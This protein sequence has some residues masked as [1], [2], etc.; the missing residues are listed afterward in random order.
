MTY[1][2]TPT[3][4]GTNLERNVNPRDT[5]GL[6]SFSYNGTDFLLHTVDS[7]EAFVGSCEPPGRNYTKF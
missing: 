4:S 3:D 7:V 5:C 1:I 6:T 2:S